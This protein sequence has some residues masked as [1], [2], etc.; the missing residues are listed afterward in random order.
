[1]IAHIGVLSTEVSYTVIVGLQSHA[2]FTETLRD[3]NYEC[4]GD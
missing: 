1:M 2:T 4:L 3:E